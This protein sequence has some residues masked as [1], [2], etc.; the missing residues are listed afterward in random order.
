MRLIALVD[1]C[2]Q[3][4]RDAMA[5]KIVR[6][7]A[8]LAQWPTR[9]QNNSL[10]A[11]EDDDP[12]TRQLFEQAQGKPIELVRIVAAGRCHVAPACP[13]KNA[14]DAH[15][16]SG[17]LTGRRPVRLR[18]WPLR[19]QPASREYECALGKRDRICRHIEALRVGALVAHL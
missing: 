14:A 7:E 19:S 11:I 16:A 9:R 4:L 15:L 10:V 13:G 17:A 8:P 5:L 3:D 6:I 12:S 18:S 1:V 2:W